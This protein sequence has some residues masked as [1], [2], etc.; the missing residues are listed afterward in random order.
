MRHTCFR[1]RAARSGAVAL[2]AA[3]SLAPAAT[4][5]RYG[6]TLRVELRES[7]E[8]PDPPQTGL[9]AEPARAFH[10][11]RW[12]PG[13][14]AVWAADDEADGGRPF[15]DGIEINLGRPLREQ[16]LDL[17]LGKAD[18]IEVGPNEARRPRR[19]LSSAPVRLLAL[20]FDPR[21]ANAGAREALALAIDRVAIHSA[22]L[23]RQGE[24]AGSLL[25]QWLSGYAFLFPAAQDLERARSLAASLPAGA[26]TLSL[27]YDAAEP[28][29]RPIAERIAVNAR[30]AGLLVSV[31]AQNR[32]AD[33]R[34]EQVR[35][36]S[37]DPAVAL[38]GMAAALGLGEPAKSADPEALYSAERGLLDG[39]RAVPLFHLPDVYGAGPRVRTWFS[40]GVGKLGEWRLE[41]VWLERT[42][43]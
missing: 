9:L 31:S 6:G 11:E 5:P 33:V 27:A 14:R 40:P 24:I 32:H 7:M 38:A 4:R 26:R 23:Q 1:F 43:P 13:R 2:L 18:L 16:A 21:V 35:I 28:L 29:A 37:L 17:E 15:L 19:T 10:I 12:E 34:L 20:V 8:T 36:D 3:A 22:L 30:D 25:P 39:R 41:N 42:L